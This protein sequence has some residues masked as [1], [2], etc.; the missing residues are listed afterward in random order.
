MEWPAEVLIRNLQELPAS[1]Q[2][3]CNFKSSVQL[4]STCWM[5]CI[6]ELIYN[7]KSIF[8]KMNEEIQQFAV[9]FMNDN[10][11]LLR[12]PINSVNL[13][14]ES[15]PGMPK[16][17]R[18]I[19]RHRAQ[20]DNSGK[21]ETFEMN[22]D[23][24]SPTRFFASCVIASAETISVRN[25]WR[26][27]PKQFESNLKFNIGNPSFL[28][29][30]LN[31]V[32]SI[33]LDQIFPYLFLNYIYNH[34]WLS[35]KKVEYDFLGLILNIKVDDSD[36]HHALT[37]LP[38]KNELIICNHEVPYFGGP[39]IH[40]VSQ[41]KTNEARMLGIFDPQNT[42][43]VKSITGISLYFQRNRLT[44][45]EVKVQLMFEKIVNE[46]FNLLEDD[47]EKLK[48]KEIQE[49]VYP[50]KR[51]TAKEDDIKKWLSWH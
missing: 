17:V 31:L 7:T 12:R 14:N 40:R 51:F 4:G 3:N 43:K 44:E 2:N 20:R 24:A 39:Q 18:D 26:V 21:Q 42:H 5:A 25:V 27:Q 49:R 23:P 34:V 32:E 10:R 11:T 16:Q 13:R 8:L 1:L 46:T 15:C 38:C 45:A 30:E 47:L 50:T 6:I 48:L 9:D 29:F 41:I 22:L 19:F 28:S 36:I 35:C 37:L 33:N